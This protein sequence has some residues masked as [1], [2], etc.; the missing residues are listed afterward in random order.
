MSEKQERFEPI[1][2]RMDAYW[3]GFD[4]TGVAEIDRIL[5]AIACAGKSFHHTEF[6]SDVAGDYPGH[7]GKTPIEWIQNAANDAAKTWR[8]KCQK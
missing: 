6:W 2:M 1:D 4:K 7:K 5:S 8:I 3:Y